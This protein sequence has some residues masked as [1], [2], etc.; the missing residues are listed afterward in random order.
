[1]LWICLS[2]KCFLTASVVN[3]IFLKLYFCSENADCFVATCAERFSWWFTLNVFLTSR[4][5]T[6]YFKR[7]ASW[8]FGIFENPSVKNLCSSLLLDVAW[9]FQMSCCMEVRQ[10]VKRSH[11]PGLTK[12]QLVLM[13]PLNLPT[14]PEGFV[15]YVMWRWIL[16]LL[17]QGCELWWVVVVLPGR[18]SMGCAYQIPC[19]LS[20][21]LCTPR[22]WTQW[23]WHGSNPLQPAI[24]NLLMQAMLL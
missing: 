15:V 4:Q 8:E 24:W 2:W 9:L 6:N 21:A 1:M 12:H 7:C 14:L 3:F 11:L 18:W 23:V 22:V 13:V 19:S 20:P 17:L 16:Q 5:I 10:K